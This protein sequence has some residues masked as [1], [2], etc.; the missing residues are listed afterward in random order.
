MTPPPTNTSTNNHQH[1]TGPRPQHYIRAVHQR[2]SLLNVVDS[3]L[4]RVSVEGTVKTFYFNE[5]TD[6][7]HIVSV[8]NTTEPVVSRKV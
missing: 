6:R 4:F 1:S 8:E 5:H 3:T 2:L 7:I